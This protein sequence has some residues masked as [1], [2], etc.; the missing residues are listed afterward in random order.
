MLLRLAVLIDL[1]SE[2]QTTRNDIS[3]ISDCIIMMRSDLCILVCDSARLAH[4]EVFLRADTGDAP[5]RIH[6]HHNRTVA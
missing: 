1:I 6:I 4:F 2:W 5:E 3:Y